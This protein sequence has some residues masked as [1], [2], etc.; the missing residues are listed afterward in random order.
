MKF[1]KILIINLLLLVVS[2]ALLYIG[3]MGYDN[4][5]IAPVSLVSKY[6]VFFNLIYLASKSNWQDDLSQ[7][8]AV[9][10][11]LVLIWN[12]V[13]II[14]GI[15]LAQDYWDWKFLCSTSALFFFIPLAFFIG[16]SLSLTQ[17]L[18]Y[19]VIGFL[20]LFGFIAIPIGLGTNQQLYSRLMIPV[21]F[22]IV[23]IPYLKTRY[24][25][26]IVIVSITSIL[27]VID[28]RTNILKIGISYLILLTWYG[29]RYISIVLV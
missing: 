18:V 19:Y 15:F 5:F 24:K 13:T 8:V 14:R 7:T 10:F 2:D 29:R 12:V 27:V 6:I 21:S 23:M 4:A 26:L 17:A 25:L 16:K 9:L 20:F 11:K 28:F 3:N 22:F 1:R